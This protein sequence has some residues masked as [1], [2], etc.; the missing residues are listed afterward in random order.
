MSTKSTAGSTG[1]SWTTQ[2]PM[3][4]PFLSRNGSEIK[5]QLPTMACLDAYFTNNCKSFCF[6]FRHHHQMQYTCGSTSAWGKL[7][8][9]CFICFC[10]KL[11]E[12]SLFHNTKS[13]N[14]SWP[15]TKI[16]SCCLSKTSNS[17]YSKFLVFFFFLKSEIQRP[18]QFKIPWLLNV[19]S[20]ISMIQ[21]FFRPFSS[22]SYQQPL[23]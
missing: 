5:C 6:F 10:L 4:C 22:C 23:P 7:P 16:S 20:F 19:N 1:L 18:K 17:C 8:T 12:I 11:G 14:G 2:I 9:F 21:N 13:L 15:S 3:G